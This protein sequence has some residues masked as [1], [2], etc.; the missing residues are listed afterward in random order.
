MTAPYR[1]PND[2]LKT[3]EENGYRVALHD[4]TLRFPT[5]V[6]LRAQMDQL[7]NGARSHSKDQ[8]C[9]PGN[10]CLY[11]FMTKALVESE[12]M[13]DDMEVIYHKMTK[14]LGPIA[15]MI[16][17]YEQFFGFAMFFLLLGGEIGKGNPAAV[18]SEIDTLNKMFAL[19]EKDDRK[20]VE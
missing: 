8:P 18:S 12:E 10:E 7:N 16:I 20:S 2:A 1:N 4:E 14:A 6:T 17:N 13:R 3:R 19:P 5:D 15:S 9:P 11:C